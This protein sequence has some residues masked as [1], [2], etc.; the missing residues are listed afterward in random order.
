MENITQTEALLDNFAAISDP[1]SIAPQTV[2]DLLTN[3]LDR[4]EQAIQDIYEDGSNILVGD[5]MNGGPLY[6]LLNNLDNRVTT[7][8][9]NISAH[10]SSIAAI[11]RALSQ[12]YLMPHIRVSTKDDELLKTLPSGIYSVVIGN[13]PHI[14][15]VWSM[16]VTIQQYL[17]RKFDKSELVNFRR[18]VNG[19]WADWTSSRYGMQEYLYSLEFEHTSDNIYFDISELPL[20]E[21][22]V[23]IKAYQDGSDL[24]QFTGICCIHYR[25]DENKYYYRIIAPDGT[26]TMS[27]LATDT[28]FEWS[29][30]AFVT[31]TQIT[32]LVT[33]IRTHTAMINRIGESINNILSDISALEQR[34]ETNEDNINTLNHSMSSF[35]TTIAQ[36]GIA[37][38][39]LQDLIGYTIEQL[40]TI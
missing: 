2:A 18:Q 8:T 20:S 25:S 30:Q 5:A 6:E 27:R 9:T 7:N 36:H 34:V 19:T 35:N 10:T 16:S 13:I 38:S 4:V 23:H 28:T 31:Q 14:L 11:Q 1:N 39:N 12:A 32:N 3:L 26:Y 40:Q 29:Y 15:I 37:I 24:T 22:V 17:I 21:C 33:Q